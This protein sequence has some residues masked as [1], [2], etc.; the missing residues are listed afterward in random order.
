MTIR[1]NYG[2]G[3]HTLTVIYRGNSTVARSKD[4]VTFRIYR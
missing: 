2:I 3:K 4:K 1:K